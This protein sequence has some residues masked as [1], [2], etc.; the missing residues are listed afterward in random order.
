MTDIYSTTSSI[1]PLT[2]I[3]WCFYPVA[4]LV[5]I[6]F[7]L[8]GGFDDDND[9]NDGGMMVPAYSSAKN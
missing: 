3:L 2:A 5:L 7:L 9:D 6:E 1:S 4:I 8:G